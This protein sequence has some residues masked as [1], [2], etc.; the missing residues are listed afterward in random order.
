MFRA[1]SIS[2]ALVLPQT[3]AA[4]T[5]RSCPPPAISPALSAP[6]TLD[7][8][9]LAATDRPVPA[10]LGRRLDR[11]FAEALRLGSDDS[12]PARAG[13]AM[14][15]IGHGQWS[16]ERRSG[17]SANAPFGWASVSKTATAIRILQLVE[18]G[19]LSLDTE[20]PPA[21][22]GQG[23]RPGFRVRHL[24]EHRSGLPTQGPVAAPEMR[25]RLG[26][27]PGKGWQY[28]NPGYRLLGHAI[29]QADGRPLADALHEAVFAPVGLTALR[30]TGDGATGLQGQPADIARLWHALFAGHLLAPSGVDAMIACVW[31][32]GQPALYYGSG[33]MLYRLGEAG[34]ATDEVWIGHS[35]G[36]QQARAVAAWVPE[37][38]IIVAVSL[39][40]TA[41]VEAI[42]SYL[43]KAAMAALN[44]QE[45]G[46]R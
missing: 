5:G 41:P 43:I 20:L 29:E 14:R 8:A 37:R 31:P 7:P 15:I 35:G 26:F 18:A 11:A 32:M 16:A 1:L 39:A 40:G 27:P 30:T 3:L 19:A 28:S 38:Q 44:Q 24:L 42:A 10:S 46:P 12:L 9:S 36:E 4:E 45:A 6:L 13:A 2:L 33:M 17:D 34:A 25:D 23:G 21:A 22:S